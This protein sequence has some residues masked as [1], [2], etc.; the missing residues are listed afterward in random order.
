MQ[1]TV[2]YEFRP[3]CAD[4]QARILQCYRQNSQQTLGCS[5]L[6]SQYMHC[7]RQ[8]KQERSGIFI[9]LQISPYHSR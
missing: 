2:R 7:V 8:A 9:T 6:A 5:A 3:V 1:H 4:L